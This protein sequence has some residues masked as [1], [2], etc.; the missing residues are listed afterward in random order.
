MPKRVRVADDRGGAFFAPS[1]VSFSQTGSTLLDLVMGGGY[2]NGRVINVCGD[3]STG[4]TQLGIEGLANAKRKWPDV[5]MRYWDAENAFDMPYAKR[6]GCP[7]IEPVTSVT[8]TEAWARD[9]LAWL[10]ELPEGGHAF[11]VLDSLDALADDAELA[12]EFGTASYGT[13]KA[14][15]LSQFFRDYIAQI[16]L[17]GVTL[18]IVSQLRDKIG[19]GYGAKE[20]RSGGRALDYYA[21]QI[22]WL[23]HT[24]RLKRTKHGVERVVGVSIHAKNEK[25]KVG[26]PFRDCEYP[27]YFGFGIDDV[28]SMFEWLLEV[29]RT[30]D[31]GLTIEQTKKLLSSVPKMANDEWHQYRKSLRKVVRAVWREVYADDE[32]RS[33]YGK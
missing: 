6:L 31:M 28:Q 3:K 29:K 11:G 4:K 17:K 33:K 1:S 26:E 15:L 2:A 13:G 32:T 30:R 22:V 8:T 19:V 10:S 18:L 25:N 9:V 7:E 12:V 20:T 16:K 23:K 24:A 27:L 14:K 21:S 5:A